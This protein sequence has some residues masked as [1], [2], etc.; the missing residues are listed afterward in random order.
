M[1]AKFSA[2][3]IQVPFSRS[4]HF[5]GRGLADNKYNIEDN[6]CGKCC[7]KNKQDI[8]ESSEALRGIYSSS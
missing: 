5:W 1:R 4:S 6:G 3:D 7:G 8:P 2:R